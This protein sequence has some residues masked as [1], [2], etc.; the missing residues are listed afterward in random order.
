MYQKEN[1]VMELVEKMLAGS[2]QS[3][4]RLI[5][6][7]EMDTQEV[8]L[9]MKG[10]QPHIGNAYCI[11]FTGPPGAGKSTLVD[12]FTAMCRAKGLSVG[13]IAVDP[14]SPFS[15]GALLGDRIRMQ[16]HY[17]DSGV[18]IRSMATR[19]S[20]GGIPPATKA[21]IKLMDAFGMDIILIETVGVGQVEV[22]VM[23]A[24]D[25]VVVVLCPEAGDSIQTMKAGLME[26]A[27]IFAVNKADRPGANQ[28]VMELEMQQTL[29]AKHSDWQVP[30]IAAQALANVG[31]EELYE[32]IARHRGLLERTGQLLVR[33]EEQ[34]REHLLQTIQQRFTRLLSK[35]LETDGPLIALSKKVEKG[36]LD[37]YTAAIA[38][39]SDKSAYADWMIEKESG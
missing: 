38:F 37:P 1:K 32:A 14:T 15:G 30:V 24:V 5:T 27:D 26:I 2:Q 18:F 4:S 12:K 16:Q 33:R 25:S 31:I 36:E 35:H 3:L 7:V 6:A 34:L 17:L 28:M 29:N 9:I 39:L 13:I 23:K 11:G 22:D 21:T 8:P 10:I 20:L 19:G